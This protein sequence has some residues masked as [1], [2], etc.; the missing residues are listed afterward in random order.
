[1]CKKTFFFCFIIILLFLTNL[2]SQYN[3]KISKN[4]P[5]LPISNNSMYMD[6]YT[7][8][9]YSVCYAYILLGISSQFCKFYV[10]NPADIIPIGSP[11][12]SMFQN[13]DFANPTGVWKFYV[14]RS[15]YPYTIFEVDTSTGQITSVGIPT[16]LKSGHR[17][18]VLSWD[19]T[20]NTFYMI[21][22]NSSQSEI[23]LYSMYWPTKELTWIGSSVTEPNYIWSGSFNGNGTFFGIDN[24][25]DALWKVNKYT[26][27]W[28]EVGA[29]GYGANYYNVCGFDKS[30]FSK[31]LW[32]GWGSIAGLFEVD[33]ATGSA[34]LIGAYGSD[35]VI[36]A[37][38]FIPYY[39]P[40]IIHTPLQNTTNLI[41]PYEVNANIFSNG[42]DIS[43][44]KLYWSR[45]NINIT[46]S[47]SMMITSGNNWKANI[48]G[49][50]QNA[51]YRYYIWAKDFLNRTAI[52]PFNAPESIYTFDAILDTSKPVITHTPLG[53]INI[54]QWPDS[55]IASVTDNF[56]I[57]SVWVNWS[58][59]SNDSNKRHMKLLNTTGNTYL[60]KFNSTYS[61]VRAGDTIFY[62]IYAQDNSPIHNKDST[63][64][65]SFLITA[66]SFYNCIGYEN[67]I[68][69][70]GPFNT[71]FKS[72]KTQMLYTA[73]EIL[74]N[75]GVRG[76]VMQIA[77]Y[78]VHLDTTTM[79]SLTVKMQNTT[80]TALNSGFI[81]SYWTI[82]YSASY[83]VKST[84]WQYIV[85]QNPYFWD[86]ESNLLI[87]ICIANTLQSSN[88]IYVQG[89]T[90]PSM[91][92]YGYRSGD[93]LACTVNPGNA[94]GDNTKPNICFHIDP[95]LGSLA[96]V[97]HIPN[98][99]NLYQ[100]YPN[101][102]NP[103]TK[104]NYDIPKQG[105]VNLRIFDILGREVKTLV[106]EV[107][108]AGTYS[109]DFNASVLPSGIYL[110]KL[111]C[112]GYVNIKR[113]I[114]L[115]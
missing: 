82:V 45:N 110:Y 68:V 70:S 10:G 9:P 24:N 69:P 64:K 6:S 21:S 107:K 73:S 100:N 108:S 109:V 57:D 52:S 36:T 96:N 71:Y 63:N 37:A 28:T 14:E 85:L 44:A 102:F 41:G 4:I 22:Q 101:P 89:S 61:D 79:N 106:N 112:S 81:D 12:D 90:A 13:G 11:V 78:I 87:E 16:N 60:S 62:R 46:D 98:N 76:S 47:L 30:N 104:I 97:T 8:N 95:V 113:M 58:I 65:M 93:T 31:M 49:N 48:P 115:K 39:G 25:T 99:F 50:G 1:M 80:L 27:V 75:G 72:F 26:G 40:Q 53:N 19:Q 77:F 17:P 42:T 67:K 34:T 32:N 5:S 20:T 92:Y 74:S 38:Y 66:E 3:N 105:F 114:L 43:S 59:S 56:G 55:V 83:A 88:G 54:L 29:L 18:R 33:T 15:S 35:T 103:V 51:T 91:Y 2:Y 94:F 111:E 86:G 7:S 84:G 23:Q